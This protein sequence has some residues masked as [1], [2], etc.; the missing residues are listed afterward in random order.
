MTTNERLAR[1]TRRGL[2]AALVLLVVVSL[3]TVILARVVPLT[4]RPTFV[5]AGGS[6]APAIAVGSAVIVEPVAPESI[7]VGDIV[8]LRSGPDRAIFTHRV[9]RVVD[10]D[11]TTWF[12]TQGDANTGP[13]PSLTSETAVIG[14]VTTTIPAI[15][16]LI[17]LISSPSGITFV[18]ALG[19][20]L[21][22]V[23][24]FI[25]APARSTSTVKTSDLRPR[26][27][28]PHEG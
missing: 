24:W 6:M 14:R 2:D 5:V 18:V 17:A 4:G 3:L 8:S 19:L 23:G 27:V 7:V 11:G 20:L 12:E 26:A 22:L 21:L 15:G 1:W 9:I 10:R 13:D 25:E 28:T 16:Y